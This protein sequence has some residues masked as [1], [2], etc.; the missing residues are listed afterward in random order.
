MCIYIYIPNTQGVSILVPSDVDRMKRVVAVAQLTAS[1]KFY[2]SLLEVGCWVF[3]IPVSIVVINDS[4]L[5]ILVKEELYGLQ[6][7]EINKCVM[8]S[9]RKGRV[10]AYISCGSSCCID[11]LRFIAMM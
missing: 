1:V 9:G 11:T 5:V 6:I 3:L 10:H 4:G 7:E 2:F 8:R